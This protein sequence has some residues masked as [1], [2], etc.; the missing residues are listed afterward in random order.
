MSEQR[1]EDVAREALTT[2]S[3]YVVKSYAA[4][5]LFPAMKA[6]LEGERFISA[7]L[8]PQ[9]IDVKGE[10]TQTTSQVMER[11]HEVNCYSD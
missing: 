3:G 10:L 2:G 9:L 5:E 7:R 1:S 6:V 11:R 8:R 4:R